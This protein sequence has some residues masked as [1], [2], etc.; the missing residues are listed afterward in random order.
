MLNLDLI[1]YPPTTLIP[2]WYRMAFRSIRAVDTRDFYLGYMA[3]ADA[4][5]AFMGYHVN[6]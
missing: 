5:I 1:S 3:V 6:V 4:N 2:F